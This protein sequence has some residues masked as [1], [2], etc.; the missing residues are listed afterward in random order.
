MEAPIPRV[1][2]GWL[3]AGAIVALVAEAVVL[4]RRDP[5]VRTGSV[6]FRL[7]ILPGLVLL[8]PLVLARLVRSRR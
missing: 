3:T 6:G 5:A 2:Y 7:V 8:W 4:P 1:L